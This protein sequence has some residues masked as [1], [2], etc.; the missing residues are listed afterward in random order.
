MMNSIRPDTSASLLRSGEAKDRKLPQTGDGD[1]DNLHCVE[2]VGAVTAGV[3]RVVGDRTAGSW[4]DVNQGSRS[5]ARNGNQANSPEESTPEG[6]RVPVGAKKSRNGD[7]AKGSREANPDGDRQSEVEPPQVP[8]TDK[9]GGEELWQRYK[10]ERGVWS[11]RMLEA[12]E[13]GVKGGKWFSLID[14]VYREETLAKAWEKVKSNAGSCC[15]DG[16][17][18]DRFER[19]SQR[20]LEA[21]N[22]QLKGGDYRPL[23]ARRKWLAKPGSKEKRPLGIPAVC[24]RVVQTAAKMVMEPIFEKEFGPQSY[25]FRPELGCKDALR[26]VEE[27][28]KSGYWHVVDIDIKKFFDTIPHDLLMKLVEERIADG[29]LLELVEKFLKAGVMEGM[30]QWDTEEGTLQ[31]GVISPLLANIYLN[32]LDWLMVSQGIQLVRYADD[33]VA[34]CRDEESARKAL[35]EIGRWMSEAKLTL[36]PEKTR[37]VDMAVGGNHFDFL[38]YRF[39][40]SRKGKIARAVRPKSIK[41]LKEGL[42]AMTKRTNGQS[43]EAIVKKINPVLKGWYG[44]FK[45]AN[46]MT[47][48]RLD[49]WLDLLR[50]VRTCIF[51]LE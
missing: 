3:C 41:K 7:G 51:V 45:H 42:K 19:E 37:V 22:G 35:E 44:Y 36:H 32:P 15:V 6:D 43:L 39:W 34:M 23:P 10:A 24:D 16:I 27:L 38:G 40:R 18:V 21:V 5:G 33:M 11:L 26:R 20:R 17:T 2:T 30:D 14:K 29:R 47:L 48:G 4:N 46:A 13:R 31:G 28:L 49:G 9:Q 8:A 1:S 50:K 12:L 25:G